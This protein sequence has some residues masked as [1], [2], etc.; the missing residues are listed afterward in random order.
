MH[1]NRF[2]VLLTLCALPVAA[3]DRPAATNQM[4]FTRAHYVKSEYRIA[5]RDGVKLFTI[6]YEPKDHSEPHPIMLLRTPYS[7]APYGISNY[8]RSALGPSEAFSRENFIFA[9]QDVRGRFE[10]EGEFVDN[11]IAK[12]NWKGRRTR[13]RRRTRMD[14]ID[15][16]VK[17]IPGKQRARGDVGHFVSGDVRGVW[18]DPGASGVEGGVAAGADGRCG[19]RGRRVS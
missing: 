11:P 17:N 8:Y 18:A 3:Q 5:M 15:W 10:S 2:I 4:Q 9:Y 16:L 13:T 14:T 7:V 19:R 1:L 12:T 6:V